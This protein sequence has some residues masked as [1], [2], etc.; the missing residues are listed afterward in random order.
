[1]S[2]A[3][4]KRMNKLREYVKEGVVIISTSFTKEYLYNRLIC[5]VSLCALVGLLSIFAWL[6]SRSD[7]FR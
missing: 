2:L 3:D 5:L 1:M 7:G 4:A 6:V